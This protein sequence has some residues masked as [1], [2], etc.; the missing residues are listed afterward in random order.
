LSVDIFVASPR[1]AVIVTGVD[2]GTE[3][4]PILNV[5]PLVPEGIVTSEGTV[6]TEGL[7]LLSDTEIPTP[8]AIPFSFTVPVELPPPTTE[9]G[10]SDS[11]INDGAVTVRVA[12]FIE[13]LLLAVIVIGVD[14]E[15]GA[16]VTLNVSFVA[17][18]G[19]V[20]LVGTPATDGLLD[21]S[22]TVIPPEYAGPVS[23]I[24]PATVLPPT[25]EFGETLRDAR[26]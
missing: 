9:P 20:M 17:P 13:P 15:T 3:E 2:L 11:E 12:D 24:V 4:V 21:V 7:P 23:V 10:L 5:A 1:L 16:V 25:A 26:A 6:A 14:E 8:G 22:E 18:A 19:T